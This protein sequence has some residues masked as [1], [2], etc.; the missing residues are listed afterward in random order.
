MRT[1]EAWPVMSGSLDYRLQVEDISQG[2]RKKLL[3]EMDGWNVSGEILPINEGNHFG[4][5]FSRVFKDKKEFR[6]WYK[7]FSFPIKIFSPS[8]ESTTKERL[9]SKEEKGQKKKSKKPKKVKVIKVKAPKTSKKR[10][11]KT[12]SNC[13]KKGHIART[14]KNEKVNIRVKKVKCRCSKCGK[15]GHSSRKCDK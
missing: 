6:E 2:A 14:C 8:G 13:G 3:E 15:K 7:S 4:L 5:I 10:S 1:V 12:C 11:K 9:H